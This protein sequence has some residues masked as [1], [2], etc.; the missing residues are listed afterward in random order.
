MRS[1][2]SACA[3]TL[4]RTRSSASAPRPPRL[5]PA[6]QRRTPCPRGLRSDPLGLSKASVWRPS[7]PHQ[8]RSSLFAEFSARR[9][10]SGGD[11]HGAAASA[12]C[13]GRRSARVRRN[14]FAPRCGRKERT[15]GSGRGVP[16]KATSGSMWRVIERSRTASA[17]A[18][19]SMTYSSPST[20]SLSSFT[21]GFIFMPSVAPID[22]SARACPNAD[23]RH[24]APGRTCERA[25]TRRGRRRSPRGRPRRPRRAS[26]TSRAPRPAL[27]S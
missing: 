13:S 27:P 23:S 17:T 10:A 2:E 25:A 5:L 16:R 4:R 7:P 26:R 24:P 12:R 22:A 14:D 18:T 1:S 11:G 8:R 20:S 3:A 9:R 15:S 6:A 19:S 21:R